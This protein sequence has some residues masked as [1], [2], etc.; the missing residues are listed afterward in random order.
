MASENYLTRPSP[1][2]VKRSIAY[3]STHFFLDSGKEKVPSKQRSASP[4][5]GY[6]GFEESFSSGSDS[7]TDTVIDMNGLSIR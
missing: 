2:V 7:D 3:S 5:L 4:Y 6:M 1:A